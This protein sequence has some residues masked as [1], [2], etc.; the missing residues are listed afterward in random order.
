MTVVRG[1]RWI[2][3]STLLGAS[4]AATVIGAGSF[5]VA[6]AQTSTA[7]EFRHVYDVA[8][9]ASAVK[10]VL[11]RKQLLPIDPLVDV[12][13]PHV[14]LELND[15]PSA[16]VR[17]APLDPGIGASLAGI[18]PVFGV[19]VGVAPPY[20]LFAGATYPGGTGKSTVGVTQR[21]PF[22]ATPGIGRFAGISG[23]AE[24][25]SGRARATAAVAKVDNDASAAES[26][27]TIP[28]P[29][30]LQA[31]A[32][33]LA[34]APPL[35][36]ALS[37]TTG[38]PALLEF[39]GASSSGE[40]VH[41]DLSLNLELETALTDVSLL[42]GAIRISSVRTS[43]RLDWP[44]P[45]QSP[46][47]DIVTTLAGVSVLGQAVP[48]SVER[49]GPAAV[50][51]FVNQQLGSRGLTMT[52][53]GPVNE[54]N[55]ASLQ[56]VRIVFDG[57]IQPGERDFFQL[58]LG[59]LALSFSSLLEEDRLAPVESVGSD[60][61]PG[62]GASSSST[63]VQ[64]PGAWPLPPGNEAGTLLARPTGGVPER[65]SQGAGIVGSGASSSAEAI[66]VPGAGGNTPRSRPP[67]FAGGVRPVPSPPFDLA[68]A[69]KTMELV[70]GILGLG[71]IA[72]VALVG[73]GVL[74]M[75]FPGAEALDLERRDR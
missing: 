45:R 49:A 74:G 52:V 15:L 66:T 30:H 33:G 72:V 5:P 75:V 13:F 19:P 25:T 60:V 36:V 22:V 38:E 56:G 55:Q 23:Q 69:G 42:A 16:S 11:S 62:D 29:Q 53:G 57:E 20:P 67:G 18:G 47:R 32:A 44:D 10:V 71:A 40:F 27:R 61:G 34:Q 58:D 68:G 31:W 24:A 8:G 6:R 41:R 14:R 1:W 35:D 21:V 2:W 28:L 37:G 46:T 7:G 12:A 54:P 3:R 73:A 50:A 65:R 51:D 64:P 63:S 43:A 26:A 48:R 70:M 59:G 17:A 39:R 9:D 4:A